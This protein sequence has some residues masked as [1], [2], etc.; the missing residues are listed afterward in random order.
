[1]LDG[2]DG[3]LDDGPEGMPDDTGTPSGMVVSVMLLTSL[4]YYA[5]AMGRWPMAQCVQDPYRRACCGCRP[6]GGA[7][8]M[9]KG[10]EMASLQLF[11]RIVLGAVVALMGC[12]GTA[13]EP[14]PLGEAPELKPQG[15]FS[16]STGANGA[17]PTAYHANV[18][19]LLNAFSVAAAAPGNPSAVNPAIE[20][21]GLLAT[22]DGQE[23]FE[24]AAR[25]ALPAGTLLASG[26]RTYSGGGILGTTAAWLTGGLTTSQKEDALTCMIAHLNP[27]GVHVPIF[28][29]GPSVAGTDSSDTQGFT[30]QEA[31]WQAT[32][33]GPG[34]APVYYAW[35]RANLQ[36][37]CGLGTDLSWIT[38][39]CGSPLNTC[40]VQVRYDFGAACTGSNGKFSCNGRPA[41]Q[42]T[43]AEGTLCS[44]FSA[45]L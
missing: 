6:D 36:N 7:K 19:A 12:G 27:F 21:T 23:V 10:D 16:G 9:L 35:P 24:Y 14:E 11:N 2:P 45:L 41:I 4:F 22:T 29:S 3:M 20:A 38:R 43:L 32:I 37:A 1:M 8:Q 18:A 40:G 34:Q 42:T 44:L 39:I 13:E 15:G 25:C 17:S 5:P 30:V 26:G 28:L 33:P 31:V